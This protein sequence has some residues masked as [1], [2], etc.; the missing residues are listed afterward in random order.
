MKTGLRTLRSLLAAMTVIA[1]VILTGCHEL[2]DYE[3]STTGC[4]DAL[5][6]ELD[7]HYC[8]FREKNVDWDEV[9]ERYRAQVKEGMGS[10]ALFRVMAAML[11]ELQDGHVNLSAPFAT[12]YY[13]KWWSDYPANYD[14]RLVQQAYFNFNY[15]QLGGIY[16]GKLI[17]GVGYIRWPSFDYSLGDGNIDYILA[18][19]SMSPGIIIDIRD[20][21]GGDLTHAEDL[22]A[23]FVS[24][25]RVA[26]YILHKTGPGHADFS[27]PFELRIAPPA[28]HLVWN[29][30]VVV[31]TNRG[32]FSAA[33]FFT[34]LM[35]SLPNV[36]IVG[37]TTG[38]GCGMPYSLELPNGW[39]VRFSAC[40]ILDPDGRCTE[41]GVEPSE[42]CEVDLDPLLALEGRDTM[43]DF[44][45]NLLTNQP[46]D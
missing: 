13:Q 11:D 25:E 30:P 9:G 31:L 32:T 17:S 36:K 3:N 39:G 4:F 29:K 12:S 20:N 45:V 10:Q 40:P 34:A 43:L 44:A 37:A 38:G 26:G 24:E 1:S 35:K 22:A 5:W 19:F 6:S 16:Y 28:N 42:G 2:P 7:N 41:F 15:T 46:N 27:E 33:N 23:H 21:G 14:E 8:F 18:S